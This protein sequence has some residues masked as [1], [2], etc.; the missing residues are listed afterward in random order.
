MAREQPHYQVQLPCS[1][2]LSGLLV[3]GLSEE[4]Y[5]LITRARTEAHQ[6]MGPSAGDRARLLQKLSQLWAADRR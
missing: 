3:N 2:K 1:S 6:L 4:A 5:E